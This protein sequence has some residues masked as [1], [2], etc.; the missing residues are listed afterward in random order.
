MLKNKFQF[1]LIFIV[2]ASIFSYWWFYIDKI[3]LHGDEAWFGLKAVEYLKTGIQSPYG[4]NKFTGIFQ[5]YFNSLIFDHFG[6]G[7]IQLRTAGI[8][9][10]SI[11]LT[12]LAMLLVGIKQSKAALFFLLLFA[13]S[14]LFLLE[15]KIAWEVCS[16]NLF[17]VTM[18]FLY[19]NKIVNSENKLSFC[20]VFIFLAASLLGAYNHIIFSCLL[21]SIFLGIFLWNAYNRTNL[22]ENALKYI[23]LFALSL[24]NIVLL[25][26]FMQFLIDPLWKA[27]HGIC[28]IL[29]FVLVAI[30]TIY[31]KSLIAGIEKQFLKISELTISK[32]L[33]H[34]FLIISSVAFLCFHG[35]TFVEILSQNVVLVRVFSYQTPLFIKIPFI[36]VGISVFA[37]LSYWLITDIKENPNQPWAFILI[38]YMGTICIYTTGFSLRYFLVFSMLV[39]LYLGLKLSERMST[40]NAIFIILLVINVLVLQAT[41]WNL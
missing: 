7:I 13:Q 34:G 35:I 40:I 29:P 10:N 3:G 32:R 31:I 30:E 26:L 1:G 22:N 18:I 20:R 14:S 41:L 25:F 12:I 4:M 5:S 36:F 17:F 39:F 8:I 2:L 11:S 23:S 28:F 24:V 37:F 15:L 27:I 38:S 16:L 6:I 33:I 19:I 9:I 21:V